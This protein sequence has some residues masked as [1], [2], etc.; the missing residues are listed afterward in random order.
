MTSSAP[1]PRCAVTLRSCHPCAE[2]SSQPDIATHWH[3]FVQ[4][5]FSPRGMTPAL[6]SHQQARGKGYR[7]DEE[8]IEP[9]FQLEAGS[10]VASWVARPHNYARMQVLLMMQNLSSAWLLTLSCMP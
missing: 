7:G 4:R 5:D 1:Y 10:S 6:G 8:G 2:A 3:G 9:M